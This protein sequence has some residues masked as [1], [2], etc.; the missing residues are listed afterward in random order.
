[1]VKDNKASMKKIMSQQRNRQSVMVLDE[2]SPA[3]AS[4]MKRFSTERPELMQRYGGCF[5][6]TQLQQRA[7][8]DGNKTIPALHAYW[9]IPNALGT[10]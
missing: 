6:Q 9:K 10:M 3:K 7:S 2:Q 8:C 1:M 5:E 4:P